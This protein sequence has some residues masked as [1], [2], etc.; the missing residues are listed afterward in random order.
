MQNDFQTIKSQLDRFST[1]G[2]LNSLNVYDFNNTSLQVR[3]DG[4]I[5]DFNG[6]FAGDIFSYLVHINLAS[7]QKEALEIVSEQLNL[8]LQNP[9]YQPQQ[10]FNNSLDKK[11]DEII[12]HK[13]LLT[14]F[15]NNF[16]GLKPN[17]VEHITALSSIFPNWILKDLIANKSLNAL[18]FLKYD[19][20]ENSIV[21][22]LQ[23]SNYTR[24]NNPKLQP[25]FLYPID[26]HS[27][28][29]WKHRTKLINDKP[30]KWCNM[31]GLSIN[32]KVFKHI[33][34]SDEPLF[35]FE[36]IRDALTALMLDLNF[37]AIYTTSFKN[38]GL[39][40]ELFKSHKGGIF[41]LCEDKVGY[42]CMSGLNANLVNKMELFYFKQMAKNSKLDFTDYC[43]LWNFHNDFS[44]NFINNIKIVKK[45]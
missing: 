36:G 45:D 22:G 31:K 14:D 20:K 40:N 5:K 13:Q 9:N 10:Y 37:I 23:E 19:K 2:V 33:K 29:G 3:K 43:N 21:V 24:L 42:E 6:S 39:L 30:V 4:Y 7:N 26:S 1:I 18:S 11:K 15:Y 38:S 34:N 8:N 35:V 32:N 44:S 16:D 17:N 25:N 12:N 41:A 27:F 28:L